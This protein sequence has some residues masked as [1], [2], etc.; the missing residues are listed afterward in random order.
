VGIL[1][2]KCGLADISGNKKKRRSQIKYMGFEKKASCLPLVDYTVRLHMKGA[3]FL[4]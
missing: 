2:S 1:A 4:M 3:R